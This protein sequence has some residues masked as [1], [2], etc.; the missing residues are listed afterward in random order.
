MASKSNLALSG[1]RT[2]QSGSVETEKSGTSP[3][4]HNLNTKSRSSSAF[5]PHGVGAQK[6]VPSVAQMSEQLS[7]LFVGCSPGG[8]TSAIRTSSPARAKSGSPVRIVPLNLDDLG[9]HVVHTNGSANRTSTS[10]SPSREVEEILSPRNSEK[11]ELRI[12][13]NIEIHESIINILLFGF[14]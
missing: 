14:R 9:Q 12:K 7:S 4:S 5:S 11:C 3:S 10:S 13:K 8:R 2:T 6:E 1:P